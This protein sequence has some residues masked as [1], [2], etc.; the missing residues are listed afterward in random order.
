MNVSRFKVNFAKIHWL[1][2][3][4]IFRYLDGT[5]NVKLHYKGSGALTGYCDAD[6]A[7]DADERRSCTR[8]HLYLLQ[9]SSFMELQKAAN[10]CSFHDRSGIHGTRMCYSGGDLAYAIQVEFDASLKDEPIKIACDIVT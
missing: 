1:A 7:S 4:R 5:I 9:C 8:L 10:Y 3:K 6:L 2:V